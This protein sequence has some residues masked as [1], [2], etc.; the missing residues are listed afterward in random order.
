MVTGELVWYEFQLQCENHS[1]ETSSCSPCGYKHTLARGDLVLD[2]FDGT[3]SSLKMLIL[4]YYLTTV[5]SG[6][7]Q[8]NMRAQ[9]G[10][11][12]PGEVAGVMG[13]KGTAL[14]PL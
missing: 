11:G 8:E 10:P 4:V 1:L 13:W 3:S 5:R 2:S 9:G 12:G 6:Q 7:Y 14:I